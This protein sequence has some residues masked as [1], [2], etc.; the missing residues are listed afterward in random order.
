MIHCFVG[1]RE[2]HAE[3]GKIQRFSEDLKRN[4]HPRDMFTHCRKP[5]MG[6]NIVQEILTARENIYLPT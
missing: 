6:L 4:G 1:M 5:L 2:P 3:L